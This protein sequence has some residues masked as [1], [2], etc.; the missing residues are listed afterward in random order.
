MT[1]KIKIISDSVQMEAELNDS[2]TAGLIWNELPIRGRV[3][4]WGEEIYFEIPVEQGY[5]NAVEVVEEGDLAYWPQGKCFCIFFGQ[6]PASTATE[7]KPAGPVN[8]VGRLLGNPG[9]WKAAGPGEE[10]AL[11]KEHS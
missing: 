4:T 3:N 5:E 11:E 8:I 1:K 6:T 10:I 7:I 9:D 2:E